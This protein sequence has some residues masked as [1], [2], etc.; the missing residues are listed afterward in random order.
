M[1]ALSQA[2]EAYWNVNSNTE[3]DKFALKAVEL[4]WNNLSEIYNNKD[5]FKDLMLGSNLAGKAINITKTTAPHAV[6]YPFTTFFNIPHGHSVSLT[7]NYF[8]NYNYN[9]N[10]KDCNDKRGAKYV[11]NK[12]EN[13]AKSLNYFDVK[14]F[15]FALNNLIKNLNLSIN[16]NEL[17]I[18]KKEIIDYVIPNIN[19][20]RI[21]NNPRK[22][23]ES[24][25][26]SF[27]INNH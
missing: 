25:L 7:L 24:E 19:Y 15:S 5:N 11:K 17:E 27:L 1:D 3:S 13:L 2:I 22:I 14:S 16:I 21:M 8:L 26:F 18:S 9:L 20:Q 12:I 23:N 6:S 10:E 4:L